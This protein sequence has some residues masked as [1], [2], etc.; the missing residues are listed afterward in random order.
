MLLRTVVHELLQPIY[1]EVRDLLRKRQR[2]RNAPW[3]AHLLDAEVWICGDHRSRREVDA[4]AHEVLP[5]ATLFPLEPRANRLQG[6]AAAPLRGLWDAWDLVVEDLADPVL[7][8]LLHFRVLDFG[9]VE[10]HAVQGVVGLDHLY[11]GM[12]Q[13]VLAHALFH[14]DA[15]PHVRRSHG[16]HGDDHPL[17]AHKLGVIPQRRAVVVTHLAKQLVDL[18]G[19]QHGILLSPAHHV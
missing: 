19:L 6:P 16:Q 10:H 1:V 9:R 11:V 3:H 14:A 7:Q 17:R 2:P 13:I 8:H 12:R 18:H 15:G 5:D 4:L